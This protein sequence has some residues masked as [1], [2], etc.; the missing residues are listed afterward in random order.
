MV[1]LDKSL[2]VLVKQGLVDL[3]V[4]QKVSR[5]EKI[6]SPKKTDYR[7]FQSVSEVYQFFQ[8]AHEKGRL[9]ILRPG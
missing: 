7:L 9:S 4:A 8:E 6:G 3:E 1:P 2:A 5:A